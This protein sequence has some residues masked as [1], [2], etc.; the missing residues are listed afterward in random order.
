MHHPLLRAFVR[1]TLLSAL[2]APAAS[3]EQDPFVDS[4]PPPEAVCP[5][6][7][8]DYTLCRADPMSGNCGDFVAAAHA[9]G[10]LY[11]FNVQ[12]QPEREGVLKT[13]VWWQC[14]SATLAELKALLLR[15]DSDAARAVLAESPYRSIP[16]PSAGATPSAAAPGR[17]ARGAVDC[18][19]TLSPTERDACE[20]RA[21]AAA[22]TRHQ[23]E[24][25][26]CQATL[27]SFLREQFATAEA[28]WQTDQSNECE[29]GDGATRCLLESTQQRNRD[30]AHECGFGGS[31]EAGEPMPKGPRTGMLPARWKP[32]EGAV[33]E[34]PFSFESLGRDTVRGRMH[35][36]LGSGGERFEGDYLRIQQSTKGDLVT[37]MSVGWSGPEWQ[38]WK[39]DADGDWTQE[40]VSVGEFA[41]FYTGKVL[42]T[43]RG[44]RGHAMRCQL[45]LKDPEGGLLDGGTGRC[46]VTDGG[47]L[48]LDF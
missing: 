29:P 39:H 13:T 30:L 4:P 3:D 32:P 44:D 26:R 36:T 6:I 35:T 18:S 38:L 7:A 21:L 28:A 27:P 33:Q 46:Q 22:R 14:G 1:L 40:G 45:T 5:A 48:T 10:R 20:Q 16:A 37:A 43:L 25:A 15:I 2:A 41:H 34:V 12:R 17:E 47:S 23:S 8:D 11:L 9:L 42:A 19:A 24:V 31:G